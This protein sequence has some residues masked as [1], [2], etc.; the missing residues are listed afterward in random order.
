MHNVWIDSFE[1]K[2]EILSLEAYP[3]KYSKDKA[4]R[5]KL[6]NRG[7][8]YMTFLQRNAPQC[9]YKGFA[10]AR[11]DDDDKGMRKRHYVSLRKEQQT[12]QN[13]AVTCIIDVCVVRRQSR[14]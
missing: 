10:F 13:E 11:Q 4:L 1:G 12:I 8:K 6:V 3:V 2:R 7:K 5:G 9:Q 14:R